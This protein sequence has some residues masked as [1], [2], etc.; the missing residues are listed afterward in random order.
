MLSYHVV[1]VDKDATGASREG[2]LSP[3]R[4][5]KDMAVPPEPPSGL[6]ATLADGATTL[7]WAASPSL[8]VEF[9]R[10]YR[11]GQSYDRRYDRVAATEKT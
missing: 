2:D 5:V 3:S 10:I 1:G 8:D 4:A 9:Y 7:N 11:D 6:T